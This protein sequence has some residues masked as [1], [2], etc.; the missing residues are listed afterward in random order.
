MMF[1]PVKTHRKGMIQF[2]DFPQEIHP[3]RL[4]VLRQL[5]SVE[6][7]PCRQVIDVGCGRNKTIVFACGVDTL[8]VTDICASLDELP[9]PEDA[10]DVII[11]RHSLE[12]VLDPI[13][14]LQEWRRVLGNR[15]R[16]IIVL[17]D[18]GVLDTM[19]F[20]LSGGVHLHAY[21]MDSFSRLVNSTGI[22]T[23]EKLEVVL[24]D[25]SFGAVLRPVQ[26]FGDRK[27]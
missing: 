2:K 22:F 27:Q 19:Q 26:D 23:I 7:D 10:A 17:P 11:S 5:D 1:P 20:V 14:A 16:V 21:S 18:H 25:W 12:H 6:Y 9:F 13:K 15:G 4:W 24:E 3:E 8:P